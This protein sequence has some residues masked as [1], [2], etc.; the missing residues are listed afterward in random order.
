MNTMKSANLCP[1]FSKKINFP[2]GKESTIYT[3]ETRGPDYGLNFRLPI[4]IADVIDLENDV[5]EEFLPRFVPGK[6]AVRM[7]ST[8]LD[9]S[10]PEAPVQNPI[11]ETPLAHQSH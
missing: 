2:K 6:L 3:A 4:T 11:Q 10:K 7:A 1:G 8:T 9:F 5:A